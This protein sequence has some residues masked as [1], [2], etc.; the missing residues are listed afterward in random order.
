MSEKFTVKFSYK[1]KSNSIDNIS[2]K[3]TATE[4][5]KEVRNSFQV[6]DDI[7]LR[8]IFKGKTIAQESIMED[9][10]VM[11]V[12]G[13]ATN[14]TNAHPAFQPE[15]TKIPKSKTLKVIVMGSATTTTIRKL[16]S[17]RSDPL[18]RGFDDLRL[19]KSNTKSSVLST[20]WGPLHGHQSEQ[21]KFCRFQECTDAS[22]G[23]R[24]GSSTPHAWEART[25]LEKLATDP[26]TVAIF[27]SRELIVGSLGEMDPVDDRL[28]QQTASEGA[29]LLGYNTNRGMRID[30]KLRTDDLSGFRPYAELASTL[31]HELSHNWCGDHDVLFWTN[32]GQMRVEYLWEHACLMR[33]G[34]GGSGG[35]SS[36]AA[37]AEVTEMISPSA[38]GTIANG[39]SSSNNDYARMMM[40]NICQSVFREL[41][42]DMAQHHLPVQ[43]VAPAVVA[44][45]KELMMERKYEDAC[46]SKTGGQRLGGSSSSTSSPSASSNDDAAAAA[47]VGMTPRERALAAAEKR[48]REKQRD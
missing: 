19:Q 37:L 11:E 45:G 42:R 18:T 15:T 34:G 12:D 1:G 48:A 25:L 13:D 41:A 21:Y 17:L 23:S 20:Y 27:E 9:K 7:I 26:G 3:T 31:I 29:C 4:L 14:D 43:S 38:K 39:S 44:F 40:G 6:D 10:D 24:P 22:F 35:K 8:L 32:F 46:W 30:V 47:A 33:G 5:L 28:M 2:H 36:T 16:N